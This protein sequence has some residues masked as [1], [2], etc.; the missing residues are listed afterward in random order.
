LHLRQF[1]KNAIFHLRY[2]VIFHLR[3]KNHL[4]HFPGNIYE[5]VSLKYS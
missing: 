5:N 2:K 4:R 1:L 3:K